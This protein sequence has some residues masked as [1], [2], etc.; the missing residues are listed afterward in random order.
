MAT[1]IEELAA[2]ID[3]Q[4]E[5]LQ[6]IRQEIRDLDREVAVMNRIIRDHREDI[7]H[8]RDRIDRR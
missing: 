2:R 4:D 8:M 7:N 3:E 5:E 6:S 1:T